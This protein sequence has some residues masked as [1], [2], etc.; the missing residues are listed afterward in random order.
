MKY[1]FTSLDAFLSWNCLCSLISLTFILVLLAVVLVYSTHLICLKTKSRIS[2]TVTSLGWSDLFSEAL[3]SPQHLLISPWTLF[4]VLTNAPPTP[5][6]HPDQNCS[7]SAPPEWWSD[8]KIKRFQTPSE[9][10]AVCLSATSLSPPFHP[11]WQFWGGLTCLAGFLKNTARLDLCRDSS[12]LDSTAFL[13]V[14]S[15][16]VF[17]T[18][19][20]HMVDW[21]VPNPGS[22]CKSF[23]TMHLKVTGLKS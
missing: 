9:P 2:I 8:V 4:W 20:T 15:P 10:T 12:L 3:I 16:C 14:L 1:F 21:V 6:P 13:D 17:V 23:K 11:F 7:L 5:P 18:G 22:V 19:K